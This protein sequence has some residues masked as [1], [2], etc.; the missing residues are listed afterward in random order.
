[1][2]ALFLL[3]GAYGKRDGLDEL[4]LAFPTDSLLQQSIDLKSH[5]TEI[6]EHRLGSLINHF[7]DSRLSDCISRTEQEWQ[8]DA[9]YWHGNQPKKVY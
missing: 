4:K 2:P 8:Y 9:V 7:Q 1:M 3:A 6:K 5:P